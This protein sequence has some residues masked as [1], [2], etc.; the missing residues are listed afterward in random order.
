MF[1]S[2]MKIIAG[3][4]FILFF[5]MSVFGQTIGIQNAFRWNDVLLGNPVSTPDL[6]INGDNAIWDFR[7]QQIGDD[8]Y[9][10]EYLM[11]STESETLVCSLELDTR[12]TY[13]FHGDSV[14][15]TG[16]E[17]RLSKMDYD[18]PEAY[19]SFPMQYGDSLTG[20]F[21]GIGCYCDLLALRNFGRYTTKIDARGCIILSEKDTLKNVL[22]LHTER[23]LAS[24]D[25]PMERIDSLTAYTPD[26][27]NHYLA[28]DTALIRM[29]VY[30]WYAEGYRYP[31]LETRVRSNAINGAVYST[32]SY[33]Y[34][35]EEQVTLSYDPDNEG[36]RTNLYG[37]NGG[38]PLRRN[39]SMGSPASRLNANTTNGSYSNGSNSK[40]TLGG[41]IT[42]N[43]GL[44]ST[45][46]EM[47]NINGY[48]V[49]NKQPDR[50]GVYLLEQRTGHERSTKKMIINNK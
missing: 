8:D 3:L 32:L 45:S 4:L 29:D 46:S 25:Y 28:T 17:N 36:I 15:I 47:Y 31:I 48:Q 7:N 6:D 42:E 34:S 40:D 19:L 44:E 5:K 37:S 33:Y 49:D 16:F 26:S 38:G 43:G 13:D 2:D 24:R 23:I 39:A 27:I 11:P 22:R 14:L 20:C 30:R 18:T 50:N 10:V 1:F 35:P 12:Y 21:H 41:N 9:R